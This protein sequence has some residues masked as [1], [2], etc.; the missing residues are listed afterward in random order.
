VKIPYEDL[1]KVNKPY[2]KEIEA[3]ISKTLY[4]GHYILGGQVANF[5]KQFSQY[6][7][8]DYAVGLNSGLDALILS[9][10]A[11]FG[12]DSGYEVLVPSNTYIATILAIIRAGAVP[13]LVEPDPD[14]CNIDPEKIESSISSKTR[15]IMPVHLY[16]LACDMESIM[17]IAHKYN[18]RV[19]E[20][21]A[22][23]HGSKVF[24][25]MTGSF[26]IGCFSFYPTKNL[27]ALGDAGMITSSDEEFISRVRAL[28]NYGS[29]RKYHN[30]FLGFNSRLDEVQA[31]ILL[32]KLKYIDDITLHRRTIAEIYNSKISNSALKPVC[33]HGGD[34]VYHIYNLRIS[35]RDDLRDYLLSEGIGT[36]IHYPVAPNLQPALKEYIKN[37]YPISEKIHQTTLSLPVSSATEHKSAEIISEAINY[38]LQKNL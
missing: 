22:Q 34:H 37:S 28:R 31:S 9:L 13:V 10:V 18:L 21:C 38:W 7:G 25:K 33:S 23:S 36:D 11:L 6:V 5:E 2:L 14:T 8:T 15:A 16:G 19:I 30:L 27:G 24:Q 17:S 35:N 26:D 1:S 3:A 29:E 32:V 4:S 12:E 20:D